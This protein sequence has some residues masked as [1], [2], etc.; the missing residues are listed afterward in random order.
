MTQAFA[1]ISGPTVQEFVAAKDNRLAALLATDQPAREQ[2]N[3]LYWATLTRPP[4]AVE[5]EKFTA[6]IESAPDPRAAFEDILWSLLN[7]KE[8]VLRR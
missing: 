3:E 5:L 8:F 7:A 1:L 6:L 4:T 2:L